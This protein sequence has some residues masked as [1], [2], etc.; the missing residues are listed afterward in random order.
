MLDKRYH[1]PMP[2]FNPTEAEQ[3]WALE[4]IAP[5]LQPALKLIKG[6]FDR[7]DLPQELFMAWTQR[8]AILA[9]FDELKL[10]FKRFACFISQPRQ[11]P[12]SAHIDALE[13]GVAMV[14][15]F[16]I[17]MQ[18]LS[19]VTLDWWDDGIDSDR[20]GERVFTE[21]RNG[22]EKPAYSFKSL[23][24]DWGTTPAFTVL[25]PGACWNRTEIAHRAQSPNC[26]VSRIQ[27]TVEVKRQI[28]WTELVSRLE[29]LGYC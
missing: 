3:N 2:K 5:Q 10:E 6:A 20:I 15:R 11:C 8:D 29:R 14:A 28:P 7:V 22:V 26:A 1:V 13:R 27:I 17:P 18:G 12:K 21:L 24:D 4:N 16:N 25:D 9:H 19:P 23:I